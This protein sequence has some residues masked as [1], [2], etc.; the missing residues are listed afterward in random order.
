MRDSAAKTY[1]VIT[2][3]GDRGPF[4]RADLIEAVHAG[5]VR[6]EDQAR[7]AFGRPLGTVAQVLGSPTS[8]RAPISRMAPPPVPPGN[9]SRPWLVPLMIALVVIALVAG[10]MMARAPASTPAASPQPLPTEPDKPSPAAPKPAPTKPAPAKAAPVRPARPA[11]PA[12]TLP[13]TATGDVLPFLVEA[14]GYRLVCD[15]DLR[16]LGKDFTYQADHRSRT[17]LFDR[18]AYLVELST[19]GGPAR[20]VWAAMDAFTDHGERIGLPTLASKGFFQLPVANLQVRSNKP[21][22]TNGD[23]PS[24][25]NIEFWPCG[26]SPHR[27]GAWPAAST[28]L[29]DFSDSPTLQKDG[30][31]A[32]DYGCMQVHNAA[33]KQTL[34]AINN[35]NAGK[36]ADVGLGSSSG[37]HP[38]WT[39]AANAESYD[40]ARLRVLIRPR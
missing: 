11:Q 20:Y 1:Y 29:Y 37:K 16:R 15:L 39:F 19:P 7:S 26:Y 6:R 40:H 36:K 8:D 17:G 28:K 33:L 32:A 23:F 30:S 27:A 2:L 9:A 35:W 14:K 34:F 24:G 13:D 12:H 38:D 18:I 22:V 21:G 31:A 25:G 4:N 10:L 3:Q 5:E